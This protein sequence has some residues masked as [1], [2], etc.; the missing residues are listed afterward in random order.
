MAFPED[1]SSALAVF[2]DVD[3]ANPSVILISHRLSTLNIKICGR[4]FE[5]SEGYNGKRCMRR[6]LGA[7]PQFG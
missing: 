3:N 6:I 2:I 7:A 4:R 1:T 5:E